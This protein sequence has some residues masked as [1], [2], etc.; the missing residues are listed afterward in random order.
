MCRARLL[1]IQAQLGSMRR[2]C[3]DPWLIARSE[4]SV[5]LKQTLRLLRR[6][7]IDCIQAAMTGSVSYAACVDAIKACAFTMENVNRSNF[8]LP[9]GLSDREHLRS[10]AHSASISAPTTD[11]MSTNA[12]SVVPISLHPPPTVHGAIMQ[13]LTGPVVRSDTCIIC[14]LLQDVQCRDVDVHWQKNRL[15]NAAIT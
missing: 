10:A 6:P 5:R 7:K 13:L 4:I 15:F 11:T 14:R 1:C 9:D 2:A 8:P 12:S 3:A